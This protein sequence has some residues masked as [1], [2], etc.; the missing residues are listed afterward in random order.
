MLGR[1]IIFPIVCAALHGARHAAS[2]LL[3]QRPLLAP[4]RH[5]R[6][7]HNDGKPIT[8]PFQCTAEDIQWAGMTCS[9]DEPCP[10]YLELSSVEAVGQSHLCRRQHSFR[11][12]YPVLGAP[13]QRR[14]RSYVDQ[15]G[16][17]SVRG[18]GLDQIQFLDPLTGWISGQTLFPISQDP[19]FL[20]TSDG[21]ASPGG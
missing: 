16:P 20:L 1:V 19:F 18:A 14:R 5:R 9:E 7:S 13:E 11:R 10:I 12:R 4:R 17:D 6:Y 21:G 2:K 8:L 15:V 3:R